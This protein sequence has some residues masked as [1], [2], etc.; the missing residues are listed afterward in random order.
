MLD[1]LLSLEHVFGRGHGALFM[2]DLLRQY[3]EDEVINAFEQGL[4]ERR[5]VCIGPD[6]G[7]CLCYLSD[8]GRRMACAQIV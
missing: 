4:V 2:E 6:C 7:R 5:M 1:D 8:E 3:N